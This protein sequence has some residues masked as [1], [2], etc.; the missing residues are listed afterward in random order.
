MH[1][2]KR[3]LITLLDIYKNFVSVALEVLFGKACRFTPT[4]SVYARQAIEKKGP[5]VGTV[6]AVKRVIRCNPL[7]PPGHDPV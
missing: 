7:T 6:M 5:L 3:I 1:I 4:C 2:I